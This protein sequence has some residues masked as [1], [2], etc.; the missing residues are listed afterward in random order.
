M[1]HTINIF[2]TFSDL[3]LKMATWIGVTA[4]LIGMIWFTAILGRYFIGGISVSGYASIMVGILLFGGVQ[5]LVLGI[6]GEY[7]GRMNFKLSKKP[8]FLVS[9]MTNI[10][11][12]KD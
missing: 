3:P 1:T 7:L 11:V 10:T 2:V 12:S 6:F 5:L 4:F 8:L 9:G